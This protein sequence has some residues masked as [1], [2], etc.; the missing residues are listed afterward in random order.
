MRRITI[1]TRNSSTENTQNRIPLLI[2]QHGMQSLVVGKKRHH[3]ARIHRLQ[4][5][6]QRNPTLH[7]L[8]TPPLGGIARLN[9]I[10][11]RAHRLFHRHQPVLLRDLPGDVLHVLLHQRPGQITLLLAI[12]ED[13]EVL[14]VRARGGANALRLRHQKVV[15][16]GGEREKRLVVLRDDT[17]ACGARVRCRCPARR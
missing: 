4:N 11:H 2:I 7:P 8:T 15:V 1:P 14:R 6:L 16:G 3:Q 17:D 10:K 5:I 9:R 12:E 13:E